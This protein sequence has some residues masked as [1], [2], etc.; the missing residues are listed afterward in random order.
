MEVAV[1]GTGST[2]HLSRAIEG[3]SKCVSAAERAQLLDCD[4][5]VKK[6]PIPVRS[7]SVERDLPGGIDALRRNVAI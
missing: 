1:G 6:C 5:V 4:A 7:R 2:D 3:A